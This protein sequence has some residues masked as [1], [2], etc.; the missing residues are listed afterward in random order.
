MQ[1]D[2][3]AVS[4]LAR[5]LDEATALATTARR[6]GIVDARPPAPLLAVDQGEELFANENAA[7]SER[8]LE[9]LAF[10][11]ND[12][13]EDVDPY[14]LVTIR[15]DNVE[16]LLQRWPA[17]GLA[18]P[19]TQMLPPLSPTAYRDV[20]TKPAEVYTQRVRRLVVEPA[21]AGKLALDATGGDA[22]PLLA[23]TLEKLFEKFGADGNL[24]LQ[25]Y[26]GMKGIGGSIDI[27]LDAAIRQAGAVDTA[28]HLHRLIV[29]GLAT[30]DPAANAAKRLV[31]AE[32]ELFAGK[33]SELA[34]LANAMVANRLL[35]RGAGTLEVAHEAL[36]R[37]PPIDGW[38][39]QQKDAL[40]LR[41]DVLR[42]AK[43]WN[44]GGKHD[45]GLVRRG[46]R[47]ESALDL[48][49]KPDFVAIL[50]PASEYLGACGRLE[51]AGRLRARRIQ[52]LAYVLLVGVI[53]GLI[54]WINQ[55]FIKEQWKQLSWYWNGRPFAA[56]NILLYV[57]AAEAERALKPG[58]TFRECVKGKDY[59]PEMVLLQAGSFMMG[60]PLTGNKRLFDE[61]PPHL[62]TIAKPFA[63]SKFALKFEQWETCVAYGDCD[64]V[65]DSEW[66]RGRQPVINVTWDDAKRY[67]R[68][69]SRATG[70]AY[71]LLT[72]AEYEYAT[73]AGKQTPYPWGD[74]IGDNKANCIRCGSQWDNRQPAPVGSFEP[75][76]FGLYD[77]VGNVWEWVEDCYH[78]TYEGAPT[79]GSAWITGDCRSH[80]VRGGSW[81]NERFSLRS[82]SRGRNTTGTRRNGFGFRVAGRL[83]HL[84]GAA[85]EASLTPTALVRYRP[86]FS[87]DQFLMRWP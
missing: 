7:E 27:A 25:R 41:D 3:A 22:L 5:L 38:L 13:P 47:L 66:G 4:A 49:A 44:N 19:E 67:V 63:V 48:L 50:A 11:F 65:D 58:E 30:W 8:F 54:G 21:L 29:P 32:A 12:L 76:L 9:L 17:L 1:P 75:N 36:L 85:G 78:D 6:A 18:A 42:E 26:E 45:D 84:E 39:E 62:V 24:T 33:R 79:N 28:D 35:T 40:K 37:R 23:F 69:L 82:A 31:A 68:W 52:A 15:A 86:P 51:S 34:P 46:A 70:K 14:V 74:N 72:E 61:V 87:P 77:M 10:V 2:R 60:S 55:G 71:R 80:V 53:G 73:R 57:L 83:L 43:E 56:A 64:R 81:W 20:I 59:C 16:L